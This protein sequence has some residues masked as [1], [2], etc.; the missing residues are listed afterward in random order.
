MPR[1]KTAQDNTVA[2]KA[3]KKNIIDSMIKNNEND[4]NNDVIIQLAI[5]QA[6]INNIINNNESQDA[7]ILIPTPYESQSYFSNDAE[8]I[9]YDNEYHATNTINQ[10]VKNSSWRI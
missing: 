2:K 3:P 1:K 10:N 8:N 4:D 6:K 5:P 7:K 9:S